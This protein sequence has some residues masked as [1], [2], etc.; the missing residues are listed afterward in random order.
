MQCIDIIPGSGPGH[1]TYVTF[2][3]INVVLQA[4]HNNPCRQITPTTL[5]LIENLLLERAWRQTH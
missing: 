4:I 2:P 5:H 1:L 3:K